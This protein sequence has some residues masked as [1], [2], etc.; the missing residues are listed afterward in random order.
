M[1]LYQ[2]S[3]NSLELRRKSKQYILCKNLVINIYLPNTPLLEK[4]SLIT[5]IVP[6]LFISGYNCITV[7]MY[8]VGNVIEISIAPV[9]AP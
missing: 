9:M 3:H 6:F 1:Y 5:F 8:S 2:I 4:V 7:F